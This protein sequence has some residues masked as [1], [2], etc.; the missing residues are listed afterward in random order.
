[1]TVAEMDRH[2]YE[3]KGKLQTGTIT[4]AEFRAEMQKLQFRDATGK[5]WML[6]AQSGQ[7]YG[8][9]GTRWVPGAPPPESG[10]ETAADDSAQAF[11]V[12]TPESVTQ[13]LRR[14]PLY[15]D[16]SAPDAAPEIIR[17]DPAITLRES[18]RVP[19][20]EY[21]TL[22]ETPRRNFFLPLVIGA[23]IV[24]IL[25]LVGGAW[26]VTT[27]VLGRA[28]TPAPSAR[29][30]PGNLPANFNAL[31]GM[32]D[33]L[34]VAS[35]IDAA[36]AQYESALKLAPNN[37]SALVRL[38]RAL[39]YRGQMPAALDRARQATQT[40]PNDA[41]AHA[42]F[43]RALLWSGQIDQA[44]S[45][46][47][48]AVGLDNQNAN[49]H[50]A[51]AEAYLHAKR[52]PDAQKAA[53]AAL[54]FAPSSADAQRAQ[55]WTLTLAGSKDAALAVWDKTVA[56]EPN[57]YFRHFELA[58]VKRIFFNLPADAVESYR[59]SLGLYGAY[60]PAVSRLGYAL[61]DAQ[62][63]ADAQT[64]LLRAL[65]LE[66]NNAEVAAAL[67]VAYQRAQKCSQAIPYFEM[68]L[69]LD[70]NNS[71]AQRGLSE[72]KSGRAASPTAP[73]APGVPLILPTL[74][75]AR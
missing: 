51:V 64:Q 56:L 53:L 61:M 13:V 75:P 52:A 22:G 58:E 73:L 3:L 44:I 17:R 14:V 25:F 43:S 15:R 72:C 4:E 62:R 27:N 8:F 26:F 29:T 34:L 39:A 59:Q 37:A 49:A 60:I 1:M 48:K 5:W 54:Q 66:P 38:S 70:A 41:D 24:G 19:R 10:G 18:L 28:T 65:S 2:F 68:A 71:A 67:G 35:N 42:Q 20:A 6:G 33:R 36:I 12:A 47:E 63:L 16:E 32:G 21:P 57:F 45:A 11:T 55:A 31:I 46:G 50:A 30:T 23:V 40:A 74:A 69:K 7:W 9:D